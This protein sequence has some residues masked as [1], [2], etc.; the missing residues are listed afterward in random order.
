MTDIVSD[1]FELDQESV[2]RYLHGECHL[3]AIALHQMTG[4]PLIAATVFDE[5]IGKV[6]LV[7][8]WI[9]LP[10]Q[11][12]LD[13]SGLTTV[14]YSLQFYPEGDMAVVSAISLKK[15][16]KIGS[17]SDATLQSQEADLEKAKEFAK[18]LLRD[19]D[20]VEYMSN[21]VVRPSP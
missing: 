10:G 6:A 17:G 13:A 9:Q 5:G 1:E 7:H 21:H 15:L 19:P 2:D 18:Q 8:C 3:L 20:V 4:F 16:L 11:Y 12:L 14:K